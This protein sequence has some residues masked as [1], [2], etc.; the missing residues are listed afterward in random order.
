MHL[1]GLLAPVGGGEGFPSVSG[2]CFS[3]SLLP[4]GLSATKP[5][6]CGPS[7]RCATMLT[8]AWLG[9]WPLRPDPPAV[10]GQHDPVL[11]SHAQHPS[12]ADSKES[13]ETPSG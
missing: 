13:T 7:E 9:T 4:Q 10:T 12:K 8:L 3:L 11:M 2:H 5:L 6:P 1:A